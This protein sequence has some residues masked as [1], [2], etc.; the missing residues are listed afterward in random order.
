MSGYDFNIN[1]VGD[2]P[3]KEDLLGFDVYVKALKSVINLQKKEES[4][5]IGLFGDWGTGKSTL[6]ELLDKNL[7]DTKYVKVKFKAWKY[8]GREEILNALIQTIMLKFQEL[9]PN[10]EKK[11]SIRETAIGFAKIAGTS[12]VSKLVSNKTAGLVDIQD[13]ADGYKDSVDNI[14][15]INKF[16]ETFKSFIDEQLGINK[17]L[18]IFIDDLDRCLPENAIK[19]LEAIKL[20]LDA[21]SCVYILGIDDQVIQNAIKHRYGE[22]SKIELDGKD[23]LEK[24]IQLQLVVPKPSQQHLLKY[25]EEHFGDILDDELKQIIVYGCNMNPRNIKRFVNLY[26]LITNIIKNMKPV[27]FTL[28]NQILAITLMIQIRFPEFYKYLSLNLKRYVELLGKTEDNF[29]SQTTINDFRTKAEDKRFG[30]FLDDTASKFF[31][32]LQ[33][34]YKNQSKRL[35]ISQI[36]ESDLIYYFNFTKF[37]DVSN[38]V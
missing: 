5:S 26:S 20:F 32:P 12:I 16:E 31:I 2:D 19:V 6:M 9:A 30:E 29:Y 8:D 33:E 34:K 7:E 22:N 1:S 24:I 14:E 15:F 25:I 3:A 21:K 11:K 37:S 10:E 28:N 13:M 35:N 23:Y 36:T 38:E 27:G 18:V 4:F 17:T